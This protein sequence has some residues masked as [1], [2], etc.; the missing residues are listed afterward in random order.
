MSYA[1]ALTKN[2][3]KISSIFKT[4]PHEK[5]LFVIDSFAL[6]KFDINFG[7][8]NLLPM[9]SLTVIIKAYKLFASEKNRLQNHSFGIC[10]LTPQSFVLIQD[11]TTNLNTL[12]EKLASISIQL[13]KPEEVASYDFNPLLKYIG[14][15][16]SAHKDTMF[17]VIMSYNRDDCLP[18]IDHLDKF[19]FNTF[20][21]QSFFFDT[22]YICENN[23]E[24]DE[25]AQNNYAKLA[26]LCNSGSY[27]V[28]VQR[29]PF[30]II[31]GIMSLLP[32]PYVRV[33]A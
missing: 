5:I 21:S 28:C 10:V 24:T 27:K 19:T 25:M 18:I 8:V 17:R 6:S 3:E 23:I 20:C 13:D 12:F 15:M 31:N 1:S 22:V 9:S 14:K 2:K 33:H 4:L 11:F 7:L 16:R 32:H 26:L 29:K 30:A